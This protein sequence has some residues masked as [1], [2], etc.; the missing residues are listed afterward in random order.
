MTGRERMLTALRREEPDRVPVWELIV[1]R[2]VIKALYGDIPYEDF[3]E[4][5][6]LDG[7]TVV[8]DQRLEWLDGRTYRDEWGI[9]WKIEPNGIA[10]PSGGPISDEKDLE[11]YDP[12]DPEAPWRLERL[13]KMVERFKGKKCIVFLGHEVFEFSH[14]LLGGMDKLFL[15]YYLNPD[16]VRRLSEVIWKYKGRVL[17]RAAEAGADVLLTGD[18]YATRKGLLMS[19]GHFREFVLPYLA[20]AVEVAHRHGLPFIK[21]TDGNLWEVLDDI[22]GAGIDALDPIEPLAGMDIGEVK[23][24]YGDRIA[25]VGN[26]DCSI[27]LPHGTPEQVE[28]AVKETIAKAS[29]GGGHILASSNSIHPG[30]RPE[31]Y[32]AMI[33]AARKF[34]RYPLDPEMVARYRNRSYMKEILK[35]AA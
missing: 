33:R 17:E 28:E 8:E 26:V 5:E 6:D 11:H 19:P 34:G 18:D 35:N 7:I 27:L 23:V 21:H 13:E 32:R 4:R 16:F 22:V 29:P 2:P 3:V 15:A 14:Y 12:P 10:Y 1:D 30:V 9:L 20:R 25:V 24:K 31:N